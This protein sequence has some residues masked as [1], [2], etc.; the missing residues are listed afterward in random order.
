MAKIIDLNSRITAREDPGVLYGQEPGS[1]VY[2]DSA[3]EHFK[4]LRDDSRFAGGVAWICLVCGNQATVSEDW[5]HERDLFLL[6]KLS[7]SNC[8]TW[9]LQPG[10]YRFVT[11]ESLSID[12]A[13]RYWVDLMKSWVHEALTRRL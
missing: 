7:C 9:W 2:H 4:L 1:T 13:Y 6:R 12:D 3:E 10:A 11:D 5:I 8:G